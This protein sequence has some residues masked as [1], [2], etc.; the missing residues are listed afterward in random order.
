MIRHYRIFFTLIFF[1][2][3]SSCNL[4]YLDYI[5]HVESP[6]GKYNYGLYSDFS[7]GDP[8]FLVLKLEKTI[9]PKT[10]KID[11]SIRHGISPNDADWMY[12]RQILSN[13][14][15]AAYFC[16]NPKLELINYRFLVFSR[17]GYMFAL[18]DTKINKDTFNISSPWNAWLDQSDMKNKKLDSKKEHSEYE[19]WIK[20]NLDKKIKDYIKMTK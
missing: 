1:M 2:I 19:Q 15:E 17:G 12:S 6:D 13:Y 7:I 9:N 4:N 11:Y 8:G 14:D 10:L 5:Q 20:F 16:N 3:F 18:Y